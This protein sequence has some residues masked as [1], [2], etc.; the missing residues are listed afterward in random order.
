[1]AESCLSLLELLENLLHVGMPQVLQRRRLEEAGGGERKRSST[2]LICVPSIPSKSSSP[3]ISM[4]PFQAAQ[5]FLF[6]SFL[7]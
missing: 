5:I 2:F 7:G 3:F 4:Y 6:F 1:M